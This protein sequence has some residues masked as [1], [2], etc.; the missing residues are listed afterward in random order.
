MFL[1]IDIDWEYPAGKS[2]G[3]YS[4]KGRETHAISR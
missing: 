1:G 2:L 4:R 3:K